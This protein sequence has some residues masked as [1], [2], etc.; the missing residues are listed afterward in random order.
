MLRA[1]VVVGERDPSRDGARR[2]VDVMT[3]HGVRARLD[4]REGVGHDYPDD[5]TETLATALAFATT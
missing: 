4:E 3:S 1:Y 2:L 5:M